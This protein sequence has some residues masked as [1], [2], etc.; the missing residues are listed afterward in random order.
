M[1]VPQGRLQYLFSFPK[2]GNIL[3][4]HCQHDVFVIYGIIPNIFLIRQSF[5]LITAGKKW[6]LPADFP[7]YKGSSVRD[8]FVPCA[9]QDGMGSGCL[10]FFWVK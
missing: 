1:Q 9:K 4:R 6:S 7:L 10:K 2:Y 5:V 8:A 3:F